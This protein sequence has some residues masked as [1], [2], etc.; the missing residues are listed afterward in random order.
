MTLTLAPLSDS[1]ELP[2]FYP[3][4]DT[5]ALAKRGWSALAFCEALLMAG[6]KIVQYRHKEPWTQVQFDEAKLLT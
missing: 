1:L 3:I 2:R 4:I 6:A 5:G